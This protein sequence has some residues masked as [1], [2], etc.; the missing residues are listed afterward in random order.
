MIVLEIERAFRQPVQFPGQEYVRVGSY[1]KKLNDFP[2]RARPLWRVFDQTPIE[3]RI[4]AER[5]PDDEL[6]RLLDY[7]A[8]FDLL[9][10]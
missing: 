5:V 10:R 7:P 6:L 8:Y 3:N 4:A 9:R 2:Q 1:K